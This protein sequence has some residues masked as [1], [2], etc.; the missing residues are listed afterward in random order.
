MI[1]CRTFLE[2]NKIILKNLKQIT[3][4]DMNHDHKILFIILKVN[5]NETYVKLTL[6]F[7]NIQKL[8]YTVLAQL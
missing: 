3:T 8:A 2:C 6:V 4:S 1:C 5:E 7:Q